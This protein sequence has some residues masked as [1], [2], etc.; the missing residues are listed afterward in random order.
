[1]TLPKSLLK[2][3]RPLLAGAVIAFA[4]WLLYRALRGYSLADLVEQLRS[5][6]PARILLAFGCAALSYGC[7]TFFDFFALRYAK[8]PLPYPKAAL[9]SFVSL[10]IGHNLGFAALSSGAV[11]YRYYSRWG[12]NTEDVAKVILFCGLTVAVGLSSLAVMALLFR[13]DLA[14]GITGL[15]PGAIMAF[16]VGIAG[17]IAVYLA[18]CAFLRG[19]LAIRSW[20]LQ[21]PSFRLALMQL[22]IGSANFVFVAACLHQSLATV[23]QTNFFDV[24]ASYVLAN[25]ASLITHVPGGVGVLETVI[26]SM[27]PGARLLGGLIM[28]R[29]VYFLVPLLLGATLFAASEMIR[30][31]TAAHP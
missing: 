20:R 31:R 19:E 26:T 18:L 9:A 10:S 6:P 1:M 28:F 17:L 11:R 16:A 4:A 23:A 14:T 12:L 24:A 13:Q 30:R 3:L 21:L 2:M 27:L 25:I 15:A 7:L 22:L 5:A 29:I 8:R